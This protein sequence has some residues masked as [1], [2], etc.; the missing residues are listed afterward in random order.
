MLIRALLAAAGLAAAMPPAAAQDESRIAAHLEEPPVAEAP[1]PHIAPRV[2]SL[3]EAALVA[4]R[5]E[6]DVLVLS[7]IIALQERLLEANAARIAS[8]AAPLHLPHRICA[9]SALATMCHLLPATFAQPG[10]PP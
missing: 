5:L 2:M 1:A 7:R 10:S 4:E 9:D 8:G 6:D 3:A